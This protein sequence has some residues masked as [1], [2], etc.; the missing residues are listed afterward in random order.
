MVLNALIHAD[1]CLFYL[2]GI[3]DQSVFNF[4][5]IPQSMAIATLDLVFRNPK[6][7][8]R[9]V[10]ITKGDACELMMQSSQNLQTLCGVFRKYARS[11]HK[12]NTPKDPNFLSISIACGKVRKGVFIDMQNLNGLI[13]HI[14]CTDWTIH[15]DNLPFTRPSNS[16]S[17][18]WWAN[19][20]R[21]YQDGCRESWGTS[22]CNV[23]HVRSPWYFIR[24]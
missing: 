11:I 1:E 5:A 15:W 13:T 4:A 3:K 14:P 17:K 23:P 9:N 12:K 20:S 21:G 22:G 2:A 10:K 8:Q 16:H 18:I 24:D 6:I 19:F 7:F